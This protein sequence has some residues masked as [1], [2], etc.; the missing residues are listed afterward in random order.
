VA[1]LY[2]EGPASKGYTSVVNG[3]HYDRL[4]GLLDDAKAKGARVVATGPSPDRAKVRAHTI[5]PTLVLDFHDD[6]RIMQEEIF[7]PVLP[8]VTYGD[9]DEAIAYVGARPRALFYYFGSSA[10]NRT[11][12]LSQTISGGVTIIGTLLHY[13][14]E[15]LP[16]GGVG[17]S[18]LGAYQRR[19]P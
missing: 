17:P 3:R 5:P 2:P 8:I 4:Q 15:D 12:V 16:F 18:G 14:Q 19:S 11:R 9:L 10:T 7:G 13:V 6:M 1:A